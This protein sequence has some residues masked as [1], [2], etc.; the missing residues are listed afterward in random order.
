MEEVGVKAALEKI[1]DQIIKEILECFQIKE[2]HS[3][4]D[5]MYQNVRAFLVQEGIREAERV[6]RNM[7]V[8]S[9]YAKLKVEDHAK[10]IA[11]MQGS[12]N[13]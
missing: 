3:E 10:F 5:L 11:A 1:E 12:R 6:L 13:V 8:D 4:Y 7:P 9:E 2:S